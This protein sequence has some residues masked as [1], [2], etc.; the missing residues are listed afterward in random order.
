MSEPPSIDWTSD[1]D[2]S[3]SELYDDCEEKSPSVAGGVAS[4]GHAVGSGRDAFGRR[5]C[6]R[7]CVGVSLPE[8]AIKVSH[9]HQT[10]FE[11]NEL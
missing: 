2:D 5:I 1:S 4:A 6:V 7:R 9:E 8:I 11:K 3:T 10:T